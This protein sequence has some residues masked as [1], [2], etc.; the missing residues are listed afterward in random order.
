MAKFRNINYG[1]LLFEAMRAYFA[2]NMVGDLSI[3]YNYL[4]ALVQPLQAPFDSY[5]VFRTR[6]AL[7]ASC[8]WQIGQLTNVLNFL[9]DN[10]LKRIFITQNTVGIL[11][12]PLFQYAPVHFDSDFGTLP[13]QF[14]RTFTDR[15]NQSIVTINTP[16]S[17]DLSDI[18][19]TIEQIRV[20]GI[21]YKIVQT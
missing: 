6:E 20:S 15:A 11:S 18:T 4:A 13:M 12:D 10:L 8:K 3:L 14:E 16:L 19:A 7:I 1:K 21:P 9:Y 17:V 2:V 5:Q